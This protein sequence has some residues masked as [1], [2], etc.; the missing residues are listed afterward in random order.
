MSGASRKERLGK[1]LIVNMGQPVKIV[2]LSHNLTRSHR[3]FEIKN[4]FRF[5]GPASRLEL[6]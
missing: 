4:P 3:F 2:D 5:F 1:V 6:A